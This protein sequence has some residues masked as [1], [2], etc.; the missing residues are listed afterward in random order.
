MNLIVPGFTWLPPVVPVVFNI[1]V[2]LI[3]HVLPFLLVVEEMPM[4]WIDRPSATEMDKR[5][6]ATEWTT[7][8]N[9]FG[10]GT[11]IYYSISSVSVALG[12]LSISVALGM[13]IHFIGTSSTSF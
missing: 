13:S 2:L 6:S 5:P 8:K 12:L 1:Y 9:I 11:I 10:T 7:F 4:K 3:L